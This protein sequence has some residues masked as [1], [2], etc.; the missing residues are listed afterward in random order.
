MAEESATIE[1]R[2]MDCQACVAKAKSALESVKGV[3]KADVNL[4]N[5]RA[6][7]WF[8]G[9]EPVPVDKVR[10]AIRK[11]GFLVGDVRRRA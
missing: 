1:V 3:K 9:P 11:A 10:K 4:E 6:T 8:D 5:S 7:I 2:G